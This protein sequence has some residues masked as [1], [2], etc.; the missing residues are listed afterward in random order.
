M[1]FNLNFLQ[2]P[3]RKVKAQTQIEIEEEKTE[4]DDPNASDQNTECSDVS[5]VD[6]SYNS[7]SF[8]GMCHKL[9]FVNAD[10]LSRGR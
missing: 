3:I 1:T 8:F 6:V 2:V 4:Q 9:S 10:L 7:S 5:E